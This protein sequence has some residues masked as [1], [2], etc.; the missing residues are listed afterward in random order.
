MRMHMWYNHHQVNCVGKLEVG[1]GVQLLLSNNIA[2]EKTLKCMEDDSICFKHFHIYWM[3]YSFAC[4]QRLQIRPQGLQSNPNSIVTLL[5][6]SDFTMFEPPPTKSNFKPKAAARK[7]WRLPWGN[8]PINHPKL[9]NSCFEIVRLHSN[10]LGDFQI[11]Y[12]L[13]C[14]SFLRRAPNGLQQRCVMRR[15][16]KLASKHC[17]SETSKQEVLGLVVSHVVSSIRLSACHVFE[18]MKSFKSL[19]AKHTYIK[20]PFGEKRTCPDTSTF[21]LFTVY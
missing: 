1:L 7:S 12:Q 10:L 18:C 5:L 4:A 15:W 3:K 21:A 2:I 19:N 13:D 9:L 14:F 16:W 6:W 17:P 8:P 20:L 11:A